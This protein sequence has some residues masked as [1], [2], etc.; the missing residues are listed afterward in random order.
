MK[1][2]V[3]YGLRKALIIRQLVCY[4]RVRMDDK[5]N[6]RACISI[7]DRS[8]P[9]AHEACLV[10]T[11]AY[12]LFL[13]ERNGAPSWRPFVPTRRIEISDLSCIHDNATVRNNRL[14]R[15]HARWK[16]TARLK[17]SSHRKSEKKNRISS[18]AGGQF[19]FQ[20]DFLTRMK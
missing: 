10:A 15:T 11:R 14:G 12:S 3:E 16:M 13:L 8:M 7:R 6:G 9:M 19:L 2:R 17:S 20:M 4:F 1:A 5:K 18:R